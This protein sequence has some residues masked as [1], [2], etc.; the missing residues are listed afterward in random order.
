MAQ[1]N[2]NT[3]DLSGLIERIKTISDPG[4]PRAHSRYP[5]QLVNRHH[6]P[7]E[8]PISP[9]RSCNSPARPS[10]RNCFRPIRNP[11]GLCK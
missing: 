2:F 1:F 10:T 5:L 7:H 4:D 9:H 6:L 11:L 8:L 3:A